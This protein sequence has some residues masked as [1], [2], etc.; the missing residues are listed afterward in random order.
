[1]AGLSAHDVWAVGGYRTQGRAGLPAH[2]L[3]EHWDGTA[4]HLVPSPDGEPGP[5]SPSPDGGPGPNSLDALAV[6]SPRDVWAVG[7]TGSSGTGIQPLVEH[8]DGTRWQRVA[9]PPAGGTNTMLHAVAARAANEAWIVGDQDH[10]PPYTTPPVTSG[11]L[12][13]LAH[14]DG[15]RWQRVAGAPRVV[16]DPHTGAVLNSLRGV[17]ALAPDNVWAVGYYGTYNGAALPRS[18]GSGAPAQVAQAQTLIEHW[19]GTAWRLVPSPNVPG[20]NNFL[21]ALTART[22]QDSWA[23]GTY[24]ASSGRVQTLIEHWDGTAW[25]LVPSP[26]G[27]AAVN[28]LGAVA[29]RAANDAWAVGISFSSSMLLFSAFLCA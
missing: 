14:W 13:Y 5:N 7:M 18:S 20:T 1:V 21:L 10:V 17:A 29:A 28:V 15:T 19:D 24:H 22:A 26:N 2:T 9:G 27:G 6:L 4:W 16:A 25:H 8:W 3:T 23:V 12:P 11:C